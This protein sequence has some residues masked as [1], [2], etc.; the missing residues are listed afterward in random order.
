MKRKFLSILLCLSM[1]L[2]ILPT[3]AL[4]DDP[5]SD[6]LG[7]TVS[8]TGIFKFGEVLTADTT[9]LT[10]N[11]GTLTY[12][13]KSGVT[14]VGADQ[15]TYT[16]VEEDI[17]QIITCEVTSS[18]ETGTV[19]GTASAVIAKADGP[20]API[21]VGVAGDPD[22]EILVVGGEEKIT[23]TIGSNMPTTYE[24]SINEG[25]DW[26]DLT[27]GDITG[28]TSITTSILIRVKATATVTA[29]AEKKQAVT[30]LETRLLLPENKKLVGYNQEAK[31]DQAWVM[32]NPS[33]W[34]KKDNTN[35]KTYITKLKDN[36]AYTERE[37]LY[38]YPTTALFSDIIYYTDKEMTEVTTSAD[39]AK[40]DGGVPDV[41]G[42]YYRKA[43]FAGGT[44]AG[45]TYPEKTVSSE[46]YVVDELEGGTRRGFSLSMVQPDYKTPNGILRGVNEPFASVD[47]GWSWDPASGDTPAKLSLNN[48]NQESVWLDIPIAHRATAFKVGGG[49]DP[50]LS[51]DMIKR[52]TL[53]KSLFKKTQEIGANVVLPGFEQVEL[54][55]KGANQI[56]YGPTYSS[57]MNGI[58]V[59]NYEAAP[60]GDM[61]DLLTKDG[62]NY[63]KNT[64][65]NILGMDDKSLLLTGKGT[66]NVDGNVWSPAGIN[67][68]SDVTLIVDGS[69]QTRLFDDNG[70][71]FNRNKLNESESLMSQYTYTGSAKNPTDVSVSL[72]GR[73]NIQY[74]DDYG[75]YSTGK[76]SA[77][78]ANLTVAQSSRNSGKLGN[79]A[80][81]SA[82]NEVKIKNSTVTVAGK[83]SPNAAVSA[84]ERL[85]ITDSTLT[86]SGYDYGLAVFGLYQNDDNPASLLLRDGTTQISA[87]KM[88]VYASDATIELDKDTP[89]NTDGV[90]ISLENFF[91]TLTG[92]KQAVYA[93]TQNDSDPNPIRTVSFSLSPNANRVTPYGV[94]VG[95]AMDAD[96]T[97]ATLLEDS[98][99]ATAAKSVRAFYASSSGGSI[100]NAN[101][102]VKDEE[103]VEPAETSFDDVSKDAWYYSAVQYA[104]QNKLL[105][106]ITDTEFAPNSPMDR[107]MMITLLYRMAGEPVITGTMPFSDVDSSGY[108]ANALIWAYQNNLAYGNPDGTFGT[109][110]AVTRQDLVVFFYRYA[111]SPVGSADALSTFGDFLDVSNYAADA[112]AWAVSN[113]IIQGD[114]QQNLNPNAPAT[115]AQCAAIMQRY[116]NLN[117]RL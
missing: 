99:S 74:K 102:P 40:T 23:V 52:I 115:R 1:L 71:I 90:E 110:S 88:A 101:E 34:L 61:L 28:L 4:A 39:G 9:S 7:G 69:V 41:V 79:A 20:A 36:N 22:D 21:V 12:T 113:G 77:D 75:I 51:N 32:Q 86:A 81:L 54:E 35:Y 29:G 24:Y 3:A 82:A 64:A 62:D 107:A 42:T 96:K 116:E 57:A 114:E 104:A 58:Y 37:L 19:T 49:T 46:F 67:V 111:N 98:N 43:V 97:V 53:I 26:N 103:P 85:S 5:S 48:F 108:Y 55:L 59:F 76:I 45:V 80:G 14:P 17:D 70:K 6:E 117:P 38:L 11:T 63:K 100:S 8:I 112:M 83:D 89:P 106:G 92:E 33:K 95:T 18:K 65:L 93:Y 13:W 68:G 94:T 105:I 78:K 16:T 87:G 44:E 84:A 91:G 31:S 66:L 10:G 30:I 2:T 56:K 15:A 50:I 109:G 60:L 47:E 73:V 27:A 25:E 72:Q